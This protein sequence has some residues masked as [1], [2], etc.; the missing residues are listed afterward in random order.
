[1]KAAAL[2]GYFK[3]QSG[4]PLL[5]PYYFGNAL[6][7]DMLNLQSNECNDPESVDND[8][9]KN[10]YSILS[11][12][13]GNIRNWVHTL[14]SLPSEFSGKVHTVLN[15][16]D[17]FVQ[18]RNL[19]LLYMMIVCPEENKISA[20]ITNIWY[21]L[22]LSEEDFSFLQDCLTRLHCLSASELGE[23]TRG[24]IQITEADLKPM[25]EVWQ[26]WS[27]LE[28]RKGHPN[29]ID[30]QNQ[31]REV[32]S[33]SAQAK[34]G[35]E[36]Y[37]KELPSEL[38]RSYDAYLETGNFQPLGTKGRDLQ[39]DNPT[40]TGYRFSLGPN[41]LGA[42]MKILT[43]PKKQEFVYC[44]GDDLSP[45]GAWDY[46]KVKKQH[47]HKSMTV[48]FHGYISDQIQKAIT[49][50]Q[51]GLFAVSFIV[52]NCLELSVRLNADLCK[53]DRIFTSNIADYSGTLPLLDVMKPFLN[54]ENKCSVIV[55]QYWN[56]Y[57]LF[58]HARVD[59]PESAGQAREG[60][61]PGGVLAACAI[62][63]VKDMHSDKGEANLDNPMFMSLE[64]RKIMTKGPFYLQEYFNYMIWFVSYLRAEYL[65]FT[66]SLDESG[67]LRN[68]VHY[69]RAKE[70]LGLR[71][72]EILAAAS[73]V[74]TGS[75]SV[76]VPTFQTVRQRNGLLLRDFRRGELNKVVPFQ[77]RRNIRQVNLSRGME[78]ML[79]WYWP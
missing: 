50:L 4:T 69:Q 62:A 13:C 31:R 12:G 74:N 6:A 43:S 23:V 3:Q 5:V 16:F 41:D 36:V 54:R 66:E 28:C 64:C 33:N 47:Y 34:E 51:T 17:P 78:R 72:E 37:K 39:Y 58:P 76:K 29:Y 56:W 9:L 8:P 42:I 70:H 60:I 57:G 11:A 15:D 19:L 75:E 26:A 49:C 27:N 14:A 55:T 20:R 61:P 48:M 53:F 35:I 30:L 7:I 71:G 67:V 79:E 77:Y 73:S 25:K 68:L 44:I 32:F 45:F 24:I 40:L 38:V 1:M 10:N 59:G 21:S 18:A 52:W 63:A 22:Q 46:L 2:Q 65:A